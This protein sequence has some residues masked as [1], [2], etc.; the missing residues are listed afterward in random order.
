MRQPQLVR[1]GGG[2]DQPDEPRP[3]G[4]LRIGARGESHQSDDAHEPGD[5]TM[6]WGPGRSQ[7]NAAPGHRA[8]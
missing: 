7:A 3:A 1:L 2:L 4:P 6:L 8:I 5:E